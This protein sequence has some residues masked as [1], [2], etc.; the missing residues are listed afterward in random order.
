MA[1]QENELAS[2]SEAMP[3]PTYAPVAL[4][5]GVMMLA[6]GILT[7]WTMSLG[8]AGLIG[9]AIYSWM[10]EICLEWRVNDES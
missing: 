10:C 2:G 4:S 3:R 7:H 9:W 6:W 1:D 5:M 8:G